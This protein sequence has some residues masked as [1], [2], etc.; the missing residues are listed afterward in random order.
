MQLTGQAKIRDLGLILGDTLIIADLHLGYE[1]ALARNGYMIPRYQFRETVKRLLNILEE[2]QVSRIIINGDLTH[3]F[4]RVSRQERKDTQKLLSML[5]R[6]YE[7]NLVKGNHDTMVDHLDVP[8]YDRLEVDN[9]LLIHGHEIP[10]IPD[11][12]ETIVIGHEHPAI[13]IGDNVRKETY[14]CFLMG[15][16][17]H[18]RL[19][20]VPSFNQVTE[21]TDVS[22][23]KLLS[24]FLTRGVLDFDVFIVGFDETYHFGTLFQATQTI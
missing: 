12:I 6:R 9:H 17:Q 16:W 22:R 14:K 1:E 18:K 19:I 8:V 21:G 13:S 20:V 5:K 23:E 24:P 10:E 7:V 4:S 3:E 15:Q 11:N 2:T